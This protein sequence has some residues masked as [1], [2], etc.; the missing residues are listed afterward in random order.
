MIEQT[1]VQRLL[2]RVAASASALC[3]FH[4]LATPI[5]IIVVPVLSSTFVADEEFHRLLL[6]FLLPVSLAALFIGCRRH[7]DRIVFVLGSLGLISLVL[8]GY[9]GHDLLGELGEKVTTVISG[10]ILA[11][12]HLRNYQL[13]RRDG[14]DA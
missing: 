13:C 5:L 6:M 7:R 12:G 14:C 9:L 10:V 2:D 1:K 8:T 11:I 3:V 4:C